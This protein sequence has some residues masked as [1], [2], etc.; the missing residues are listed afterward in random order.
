MNGTGNTPTVE[1]PERIIP[2][3][4]HLQRAERQY[5]QS[6]QLL[7]ALAEGFVY[8]KLEQ[9]APYSEKEKRKLLSLQ[10]EVDL[11]IDRISSGISALGIALE[12][13]FDNDGNSTLG[14]YPMKDIARLIEIASGLIVP[15]STLSGQ[16]SIALA[17]G[18][19]GGAQ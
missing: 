3:I 12:L 13:C 9:D 14:S 6:A 11:E 7:S 8:E 10:F 5:G 1:T 15:L 2:L 18:N 19:K 4:E 17:A 16:I